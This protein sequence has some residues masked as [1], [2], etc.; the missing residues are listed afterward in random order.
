M[1]T[2]LR[3]SILRLVLGLL[4]ALL[5][6]TAAAGQTPSSQP[7]HLAPS[8]DQTSAKSDK[9]NTSQAI[10]PN[11]SALPP[12]DEQSGPK[13]GQSEQAVPS[14][15]CDASQ[16]SNP[17]EQAQQASQQPGQQPAQPAG[18]PQA[19]QTPRANTQNAQPASTDIAQKPD[20]SSKPKQTKRIFWIIP[21]NRAVSA[22]TQLPPLTV[23]GKL[24]L[25][26]LDS[27]DYSSVLNVSILAAIGLAK[28]STPEFHQGAA[29]YF[30]YFYHDWLDL[31]LGN[32]MTEGVFPSLTHQDP[33]FY[34]LGHG[35]FLHRAGYAASRIFVTRTDSGDRTIN[36]SEILGNGAA[37]GLANL[38]YPASDRSFHNTAKNWVTQIGLD[39]ISY[40]FKEFWPDINHKL[41]HNKY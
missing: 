38:Y 3:P 13:A 34:T 41:F 20:D 1:K 14:E 22:D 5:M 18:Q 4:G 40:M 39:T 27:T 6:A 26:T 21:N 35:S 11:Q 30:R 31:S 19:Q 7:S 33:R 28:N 23:K 8:A 16:M 29:G 15:E 10:T 36:A 17:D 37:A 25:A 12:Q 2:N 32:F 24:W 9:R